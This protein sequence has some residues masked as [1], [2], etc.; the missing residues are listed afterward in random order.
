[1]I[2]PFDLHVLSTP[3]AFILS[4]DQTLDNKFKFCMTELKW[5]VSAPQLLPGLC[6]PF[7][8]P[9][10]HNTFDSGQDR[11]AFLF[12]L[13]FFFLKFS[14]IF[15]VALLFICQG[16]PL[17]LLPVGSV[18]CGRFISDTAFIYYHGC[19]FPSRHFFTF[20]IFFS[21]PPSWTGFC[22]LFRAVGFY[23][24]TTLQCLSSLFLSLFAKF[25]WNLFTENLPSFS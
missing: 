22:P 21:F 6:L 3:P 14:W 19:A 25:C 10:S 13:L 2:T 8:Y 11:L 9:A 4:Q 1:M 23:C 24:I 18:L 12:R 16:A 20:F 15:R 5:I 17:R 7:P